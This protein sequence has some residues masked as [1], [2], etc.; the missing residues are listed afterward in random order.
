MTC[1]SVC[2]VLI[3]RSVSACLQIV[4]TTFYCCLDISPHR[5]Q[6]KPHYWLVLPLYKQFKLPKRLLSSGEGLFEVYFWVYGVSVKPLSRRGFD[7]QQFQF[8]SADDGLGAITDVQFAVDV[9]GV[10]FDRSYA[11]NQFFSDFLIG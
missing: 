6:I 2:K 9:G 7:L 3:G 8:A 10:C 5:F 4:K 1:Y 11:D